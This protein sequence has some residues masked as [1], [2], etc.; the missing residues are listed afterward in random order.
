MENVKQKNTICLFILMEQKKS[1][2]MHL[3]SNIHDVW[4]LNEKLNVNK[5]L[6]LLIFLILK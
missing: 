1:C 3:N 5:M 4:T 2:N 6:T